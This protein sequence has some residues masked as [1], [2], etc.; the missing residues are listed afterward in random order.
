MARPRHLQCPF[1]ENYLRAPVEI[2]FK[3]MELTG[4]IC[5]CGAIYVHDRTGRNLGGIFMDALTFACKGDIDKSLS[6]D[7]EDYASVDY[8]YDIHSNKI[9]GTGK[10]GKA[11]KLIFVRLKNK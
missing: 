3:D 8:D 6:L 9:G 1:C 2:N 7:P 4:G 10:T 5:T 11:G